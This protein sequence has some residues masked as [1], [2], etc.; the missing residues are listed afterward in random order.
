[1]IDVGSSS[2]SNSGAGRNSVGRGSRAPGQLVA[3]DIS[4]RH[5]G[6]GRIGVVIGRLTDVHPV[7]SGLSVDIQVGEGV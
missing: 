2:E 3:S 1:V 6:D 4:G 7:A 5:V